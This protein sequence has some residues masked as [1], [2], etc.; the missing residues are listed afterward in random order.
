MEKRIISYTLILFVAA[1]VLYLSRQWVAFLAPALASC[2]V[3]LFVFGG[4][5]LAFYFSFM[6]WTQFESAMGT[7]SKRL[8][9][10]AR[11]LRA[12]KDAMLTVIQSGSQV[13][14]S[15]ELHREWRAEHQDMRI[16]RNSQATYQPPSEIEVRAFEAIHRPTI[17]KGSAKLLPGI[18]QDINESPQPTFYDALDYKAH[19]LLV[20]PSGAGK[21]VQLSI[22]SYYL[23]QQNP[24]TTKL[25]WLSTHSPKDNNLIPKKAKVYHSP[26]DI[27][28]RLDEIVKLYEN[29]RAKGER[30]YYRIIIVVD[31]WYDLI[32]SD[33]DIKDQIAQLASGARKYNIVLLMASHVGD[34]TSLGIPREVRKNFSRVDLDTGLT[35]EGKAVWKK[36][37]NKEGHIEIQLP[38]RR[39]LARQ[40]VET[41][42]SR[43]KAAM[44]VYGQRYAGH[45]T[46]K[47]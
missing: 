2:I 32:R 36:Y 18:V 12:Q 33:G 41:G 39:D 15:D 42:I 8:E 46:G 25:I 10:D 21:S 23:L 43:N 16:Y 44:A 45:L 11:T 35:A 1:V 4:I 3:S 31:E 19:L 17:I 37:D 34:V 14:V 9:Q 7:R 6:V 38:K 22:A 24:Q 13:Y 26:D 30:N 20:A 47:F 40:M 29:R 5:L 28:G 27:V